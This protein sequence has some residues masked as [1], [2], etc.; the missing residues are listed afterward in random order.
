MI[1]LRNIRLI[2]ILAPDI[3]NKKKFSALYLVQYQLN[4]KS[5]DQL[6]R[7]WTRQIVK[8]PIKVKQ[9]NYSKVISKPIGVLK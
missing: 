3:F 2:M 5:P 6:V 1:I 9:L 4:K 7:K 8:S